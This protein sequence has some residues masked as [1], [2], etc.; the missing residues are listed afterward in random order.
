[1]G[2][3]VLLLHELSDGDS[4]YDW[5]IDPGEGGQG[6]EASGGSPRGDPDERVLI[7]FRLSERIDLALPRSF[8]AVR[9]ADHRRLYLSYEGPL[10]GGRGH[11]RRLA[12]GWM[13]VERSAPGQLAV[14]GRLGE[15]GGRLAGA[16]REGAR[17][18]FHAEPG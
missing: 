14:A 11:V 10:S 5:L 3:C 4:H 13:R 17:W 16:A 6:G 7:A 9:M 8:E 1:M 12:T 18:V 2:A 15:A